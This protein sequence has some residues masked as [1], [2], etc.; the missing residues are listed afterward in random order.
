M[1]LPLYVVCSFGVQNYCGS[2]AEVEAMMVG[3]SGDG[4][5]DGSYSCIFNHCSFAVLFEK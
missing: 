5:G 3:G 1:D 2:E 4:D